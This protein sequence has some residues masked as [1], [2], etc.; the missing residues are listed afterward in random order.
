[1]PAPD[2]LAAAPFPYAGEASAALSALLWGAVGI[3]FARMRPAPT[4]A[5]LNLGKNLAATLCFVAL[6]W[7]VRGVPLPQGLDGRAVAVFAASGVLG[8]TLCDTLLLRSLLNI[9]P[10][11]MSVIFLLV[12]VM[13]GL[14]AALPPFSESV[15]WVTW[16]GMVVCLGGIL[17]AIKQPRHYRGDAAEFSRG[18]RDAFFAACLQT[19]AIL[20]ARYGLSVRRAPLLDSAVVRMASG[21]LGLIVMGTVFGG[22]R[23]WVAEL[24]PVRAAT[25]IFIGSF[26]G[27][28]LGILTNQFGLQYSEHTGVAT[29]LN[30]LMPIYLMPL[31][32]LFLGDHFGIRGVIATLIAVAGVALM[33]LG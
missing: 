9:G 6:L 3:V 5:A 15:P 17:L 24:R 4:A 2:L 13:T 20:L 10:Q 26:F 18:I 12:P 31:S 28:F 23:S 27:T 22:L 8:L 1:M 19:A 21:T 25:T 30:S 11:R 16:T 29:T 33:M 32:V 7:S 14:V